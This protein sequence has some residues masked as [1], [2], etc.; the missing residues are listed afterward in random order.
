MSENQKPDELRA[1]AKKI[2][3]LAER[4]ARTLMRNEVHWADAAQSMGHVG[5]PRVWREYAAAMD[6]AASIFLANVLDG[7][8]DEWT[9]L[10]RHNTR[11]TAGREYPDEPE[12]YWVQAH[13]FAKVVLNVTGGAA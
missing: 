13:F 8:A 7:I 4:S 3:D 12:P 2:R 10:D 9:K 1:A 6:P 11:T 5:E